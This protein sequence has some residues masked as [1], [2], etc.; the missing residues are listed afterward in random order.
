MFLLRNIPQKNK[1]KARRCNL[2]RFVVNPAGNAINFKSCQL[3][4]LTHISPFS[5]FIVALSGG[6]LHPRCTA[7]FYTYAKKL[8]KLAKRTTKL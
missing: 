5:F 7:Y 1:H 6:F 4:Q 8:L 2:T 3:G